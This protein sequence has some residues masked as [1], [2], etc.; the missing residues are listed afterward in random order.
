MINVHTPNFTAK[1]I[2]SPKIGKYNDKES[3]YEDYT[4]NFVEIDP[5][6]EKDV[7]ALENAIKY[8]EHDKFGMNALYAVNAAKDGSEYYGYHKVYALTAQKNNFD[9]LDCNDILGVVHVSPIGK[10]KL[11]VEHNQAN[12]AYL[13]TENPK[14]AGIGTAMIKS[15]QKICSYISLFPSKEEYVKKF[16]IK[17]GF[18]EYGTG[19]NCY[20]WIK[21]IFERL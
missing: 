8:W 15:L 11:F 19:T 4:A 7:D 12:P 10:N 20:V 9:K 14:Y 3:Q 1:C 5:K 6:N 13:Y 17:N 18:L 16:Y 21:D 2:N